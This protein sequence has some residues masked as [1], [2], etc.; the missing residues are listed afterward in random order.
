MQEQNAPD[1]T[2]NLQAVE[3]SDDGRFKKGHSGNPNGRPYGMR[4][5]MSFAIQQVFEKES[6]AVAEKLVELAKN[7]DL[8]AMKLI[9]ERVYPTPKNEELHFLLPEINDK[10]GINKARDEIHASF[11]C[12]EITAAEAKE[13]IDFLDVVKNAKHG[14]DFF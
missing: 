14:L 8:S 13:A 11:V 5:K 9:L 4:N 12:G 3:R 2:G 7:G 1:N 6:F 10:N